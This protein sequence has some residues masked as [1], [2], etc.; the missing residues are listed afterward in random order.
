MISLFRFWEF[1]V[2]YFVST[3]MI[4]EGLVRYFLMTQPITDESDIKYAQMCS[5]VFP[6]LNM[7]M[8]I[9]VREGNLER[10]RGLVEQGAPLDELGTYGR[11]PLMGAAI[12]G[13][14]EIARY[15]LEQGADRDKANNNGYTSTSLLNSANKR[16]RCCS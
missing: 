8:F 3:A 2:F 7:D 13:R 9:A 10:V 4:V 1:L 11:T 14:L 15:L 16:S 5:S 12:C 6:F